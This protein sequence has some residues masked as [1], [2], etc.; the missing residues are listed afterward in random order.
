[1]FD[2]P[3]ETAEERKAYRKFRKFLI[4]EGFIMHQFSV[5]SKILLNNTANTAMVSRLKQNTPKKRF[6]YVAYGHRKTIFKNALFKWRTRCE[7]CKYRRKDNFF[8]GGL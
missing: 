8:R 1:M 4:N 6:D 3:T 2:M 5:Y 7:C